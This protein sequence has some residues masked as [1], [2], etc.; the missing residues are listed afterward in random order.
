MEDPLD[1]LCGPAAQLW[2]TRTIDSPEYLAKNDLLADYAALDWIE[3]Y[4]E[5]LKMLMDDE[6]YPALT[7]SDL[8]ALVAEAEREL[9]NMPRTIKNLLTGL[10]GPELG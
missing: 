9:D 2:G 1:T 8:R 10:D 6:K 5:S 3:A 7:E 4:E